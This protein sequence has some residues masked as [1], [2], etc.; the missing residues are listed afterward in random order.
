MARTKYLIDKSRKA[1]YVSLNPQGKGQYLVT[2]SQHG[3][4]GQF[5]GTA[6]EAK[7][8]LQVRMQ[9]LGDALVGN[10]QAGAAT[11]ARLKL[12]EGEDIL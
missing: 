5:E 9:R 8:W 3:V 6:E 7:G 4:G 12:V 11:K 1:N 2:L 10:Q